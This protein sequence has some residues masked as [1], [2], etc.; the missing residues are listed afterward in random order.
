MTTPCLQVEQA[1]PRVRQ[2]VVAADDN[3]LVRSPNPLAVLAEPHHE[4]EENF[5]E[6]GEYVIT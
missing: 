5:G 4:K 6:S 1:H 3:H 2:V